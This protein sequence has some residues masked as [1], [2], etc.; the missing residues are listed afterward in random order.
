MWFNI[1]DFAMVTAQV[2]EEVLMAA[3]SARESLRM[4]ITFV[5]CLRVLRSIRILRG[6]RVLRLVH[7]L[8]ILVISIQHAAS[9]LAWTVVL[10]ALVIFVCSVW[11]TQIVTDHEMHNE[12]TTH[13]TDLRFYFGSLGSTWMS[14]YQSVTGGLDWRDAAQPLM[15]DISPVL[16]IVFCMYIAFVVLAMMN[17]VTGVFVDT[18][19]TNSKEDFDLFMKN[20]ISELFGV[21]PRATGQSQVQT[22]LHLQDFQNHLDKK[23]MQEY[24]KALDV[25]LSE[26][27]GIFQLLDLNGN[28]SVD[29]EEFL[30]GCMRLRGPAKALELELLMHEVKQVHNEV[31]ILASSM[32]EMTLTGLVAR[33]PPGSV[34]DFLHRALSEAPEV[35]LSPTPTELRVVAAAGTAAAGGQEALQDVE[36]PFP[37]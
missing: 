19:M 34:S 1:F 26:A 10:L 20:N 32:N 5:R 29:A 16:G 15:S 17:I 2:I 4:N 3:C 27:K 22:V 35:L 14:L 9:S 37:P 30:S 12:D 6:A 36:A 31:C 24:F 33:S 25:D 18:A 23:V 28:G 13:S 8:R 7:N 21:Q 11:F